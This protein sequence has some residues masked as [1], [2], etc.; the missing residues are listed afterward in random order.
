MKNVNILTL[1][2]LQE[3]ENDK[4]FIKKF[5][6]VICEEKKYFNEDALGFK[7]FLK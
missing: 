5:S 3:L 7:K 4:N 1:N 6:K 2:E